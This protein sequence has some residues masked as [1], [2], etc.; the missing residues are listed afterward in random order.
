LGREGE[1]LQIFK[2]DVDPCSPH[3]GALKSL[4]S[5]D[6]GGGKWKSPWGDVR[7]RGEAS[8]EKGGRQAGQCGEEVKKIS[9]VKEFPKNLESLGN[10]PEF[11]LPLSPVSRFARNLIWDRFG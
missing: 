10:Y 3:L 4:L 6:L 11:P 1:V 9:M 7:E 5:L 8:G 2:C